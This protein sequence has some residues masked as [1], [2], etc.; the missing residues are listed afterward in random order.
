M[1]VNV[2]MCP[3]VYTSVYTCVLYIHSSAHVDVHTSVRSCVY[4]VSRA[5][6][7]YV[8]ECL[9]VS[10]CLHVRVYVRVVYTFICACIHYRT[11]AETHSTKRRRPCTNIY[12]YTWARVCQ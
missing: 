1:F 3:C 9:Y 10:L 11:H 2:F 4:I 8:C 7:V 6:I 12:A 5:S